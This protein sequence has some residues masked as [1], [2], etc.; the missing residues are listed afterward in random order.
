MAD[1]ILVIDEGTTST[2]AI[3]FD[4]DFNQVALAQEEVPLAYP[5]D[6]WVEQDGEEIWEKTLAVC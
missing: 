3:V 1:C 2:R 5:E 6:G 4:R